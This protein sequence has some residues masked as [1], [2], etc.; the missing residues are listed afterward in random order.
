VVTVEQSP[1]RGLVLYSVDGGKERIRSVIRAQVA[2]D[3]SLEEQ[4]DGSTGEIVQR[5]GTVQFTLDGQ[6][7]GVLQRTVSDAIDV[8]PILAG[9]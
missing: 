8:V 5:D 3:F 2:R 7:V 6:V 4:Q 1:T 9:A